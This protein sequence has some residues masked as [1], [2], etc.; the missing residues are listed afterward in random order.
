M[1]QSSPA[2]AV[3][4]APIAEEKLTQVAASPRLAINFFFLSG[5]ECI[6]KL[7]TFVT[8]AYLS[9]ALGPSQYGFLEFT[10]AVMVF[11]TLPVDLGLGAYGA[12]EIATHPERAPHFL[13][14]I[15]GVRMI[16][17]LFSILALTVFILLLPKPADIKVLLACY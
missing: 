12:R 11:F 15:T 1:A 14:E 16:L 4:Q 5:G 17:A 9:R 3:A 6:A 10:L 13:R 7:L 8:F 2:A